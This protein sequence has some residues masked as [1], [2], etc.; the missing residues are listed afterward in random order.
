[1]RTG[2]R[3]RQRTRMASLAMGAQAAWGRFIVRRCGTVTMARDSEH[4]RT[5]QP[6]HPGIILRMVLIV[7]TLSW[8]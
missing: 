4:M 2:T 5:T 8:R 1:M 3:R 6:G 7:C